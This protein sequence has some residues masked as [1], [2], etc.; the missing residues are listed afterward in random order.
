MLPKVK[1]KLD[2]KKSKTKVPKNLYIYINKTLFLQI[3]SF[4]F[5]IYIVY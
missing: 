3:Q 1:L 5:D 4:H 2:D